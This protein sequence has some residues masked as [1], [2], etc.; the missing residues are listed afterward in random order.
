MR[1]STDTCSQID[2]SER[3]DARER[4]SKDLDRERTPRTPLE[5]AAEASV[6]RRLCA[7]LVHAPH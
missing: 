2:D 5:M 3:D 4:L 1:T 7:G 6:L